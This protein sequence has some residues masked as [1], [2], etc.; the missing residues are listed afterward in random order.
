M[1]D[2]GKIELVRTCTEMKWPVYFIL[3]REFLQ[4]VPH[5]TLNLTS[6]GGFLQGKLKK[7]TFANGQQ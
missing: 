6:T 7:K 2:H 5:N 3:G 1:Y 4:V